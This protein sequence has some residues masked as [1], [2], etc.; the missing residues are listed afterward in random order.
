MMIIINQPVSSLE[1]EMILPL[2][3]KSQTIKGDTG[4]LMWWLSPS[5]E[6]EGQPK[7]CL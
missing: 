2:P 3:L 4:T 5:L 6:E 7:A 1:G